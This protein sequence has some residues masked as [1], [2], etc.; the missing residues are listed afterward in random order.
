MGALRVIPCNGNE[1][2]NIDMEMLFNATL[3]NPEKMNALFTEK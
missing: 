3:Q 2:T 1:E